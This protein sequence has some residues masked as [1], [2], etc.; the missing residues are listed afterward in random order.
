MVHSR[1]G[2]RDGAKLN[3]ENRRE[4]RFFLGD[5]RKGGM[6]QEQDEERRTSTRLPA[7]SIACLM[8]EEM[9]ARRKGVG[10]TFV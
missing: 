7:V 3:Q 10:G 6:L 2:Y 9:S 5:S 8:L 4:A 1:I